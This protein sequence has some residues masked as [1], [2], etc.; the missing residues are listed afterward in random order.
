MPEDSSL[1]V[2]RP[3]ARLADAASLADARE[4]EEG[5]DAC[6]DARSRRRRRLKEVLTKGLERP[7]DRRLDTPLDRRR[8]ESARS[9][10]TQS[11]W[12]AEWRERI[13]CWYLSLPLLGRGELGSCV[14]ALG[15]HI[16]S[17]LELAWRSAR[18]RSAP[19]GIERE[20]GAAA[21]GCAWMRD[22]V[23]E[24]PL[25]L[26][27]FPDLGTLDAFTLPPIPRLVPSLEHLES[28]AEQMLRLDRFVNHHATNRLPLANA[29]AN[30]PPDPPPAAAVPSAMAFGA[31]VGVGVAAASL[32][33]GRALCRALQRTARGGRNR[34][35][36]SCRSS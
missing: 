8:L 21:T 13:E 11:E 9:K 2:F 22:G 25:E 30:S 12:A 33:L 19:L 5:G 6:E 34:I 18:P 27:P 10:E 28:R 23:L 17:R 36:I 1:L 32:A 24:L 29:P 31:L 35:S 15:L 3:A 26:P 16:G 14:G 4:E 20:V 7:L